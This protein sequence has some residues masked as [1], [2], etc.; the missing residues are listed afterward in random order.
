MCSTLAP[1]GVA[2]SIPLVVMF[3]SDHWLDKHVFETPIER[4]KH[5]HLERIKESEHTI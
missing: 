1:H 5:C 4:I 3:P 2:I